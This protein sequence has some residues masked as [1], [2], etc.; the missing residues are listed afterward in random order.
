[1]KS[2]CLCPCTN[3]RFLND[4]F[5]FPT[6]WHSKS[7]F[8][9]SL[10][11]NKMASIEPKTGAVVDTGA[12]NGKET[13]AEH[14]EY[15]DDKR[16]VSITDSE[17]PLGETKKKKVLRNPRDL[18]TEVLSLED[19]PTLNPWT[20]RM[21]F[22]GIGISVFGGTVTTI[23]TFKPQSVHIHLVFVAVITYILGTFMANVIPR[24]GAL[25][26]FINP[27]PV[28]ISEEIARSK[29]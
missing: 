19:D 3:S 13:P 24:R 7:L 1:V 18:V 29:S 28:S 5:P 9:V 15:F 11:S 25:G 20:F 16:D 23:N 12:K 26:R 2:G 14:I 4:T 17:S 6:L 27:G 8:L 22:I 21:W 10:F